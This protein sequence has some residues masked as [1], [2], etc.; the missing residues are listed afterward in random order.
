MAGL[1]HH[2]RI[3]L[4][5]DGAR[6]VQP[7]HHR[8]DD[9]RLAPHRTGAGGAGDGGA[10]RD[11]GPF[12]VDTATQSAAI[13]HRGCQYAS[14]AFSQRFVDTDITASLGSVGDSFHNARA[15]SWLAQSKSSCCTGGSG[16]HGR[17]LDWPSSAGLRDGITH[18]ASGTVLAGAAPPNTRLHTPP[19]KTC[20]SSPLPSLH[21]PAGR[22]TSRTPTKPGKVGCWMRGR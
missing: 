2:G 21:R 1:A 12:A 4:S 5:G 17:R 6:R 15:E 3:A 13:H 22:S 9:D 7:P 11:T 16:A 14:Y 18:A 20:R 19:A 8:L 10:H